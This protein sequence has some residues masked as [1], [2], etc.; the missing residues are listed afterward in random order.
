SH[1]AISC[2][3]NNACTADSCDPASGCVNTDA[4]ADCDDGIDC[5]VDSCDPASGCLH[6]KSSCVCTRTIGYYKT[7]CSSMNFSD[8]LGFVCSN[9]TGLN[10]EDGAHGWCKKLNEK[11]TKADLQLI[12]QLIAAI[13]NGGRGLSINSVI[14]QAEACL[15]NAGSCTRNQQLSLASQLDA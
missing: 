6:D 13:L 4:S 15:C 8:S 1:D 10:T 7:H 5:T 2:D 14:V 9:L 3:D 12:Q 11:A